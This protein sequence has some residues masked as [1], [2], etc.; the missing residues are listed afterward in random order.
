MHVIDT[1]FNACTVQTSVFRASLKVGFTQINQ[2]CKC[3]F[4]IPSVNWVI[5]APD[6]SVNNLADT[7]YG[8]RSKQVKHK[9][10]IYS[11]PE[12]TAIVKNVLHGLYTGM[13][14]KVSKF[15]Y[16]IS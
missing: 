14:A 6:P 8:L 11:I 13:L 16:P 12:H 1:D 9:K 4:S 15:N 7:C 10:T 5:K 3:L 2:N